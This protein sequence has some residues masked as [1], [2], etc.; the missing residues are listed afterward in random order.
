MEK[1]ALTWDKETKQFQVKLTEQSMRDLALGKIVRDLYQ[2]N[3]NIFK[4]AKVKIKTKAVCNRNGIEFVEKSVT[5]NKL[6]FQMIDEQWGFFMA[7][8]NELEK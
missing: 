7:L 6:K 3:K 5:I 1:Y 2:N 4:K 8:F